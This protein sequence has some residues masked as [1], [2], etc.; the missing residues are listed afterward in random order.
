[1]KIKSLRA[2]AVPLLCL[3]IVLYTAL[4]AVPQKSRSCPACAMPSFQG[5][6]ALR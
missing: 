4:T 3:V 2:Y 5:L 1:M 6:Q